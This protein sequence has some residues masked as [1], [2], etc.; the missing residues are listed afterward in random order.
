MSK[1]FYRAKTQRKPLSQD[2]IGILFFIAA[3]IF[4]SWFRL[5][6]VYEAQFP[7]N[8]GG[9]FYRMTEAII[10]NGFRLPEYVQY[11]GLSIPFAYP[12]LS[13]YIAGIT[14]AVFGTKLIQF[15]LYLPAIV[16]II[17]LFAF[18]ALANSLFESKLKAG[19][20]TLIF[21]L[22]PRSITWLIMGGGVTRSFGQLFLI[23]AVQNIYLLFKNRTKKY[24]WLSILFSS[25][26]CLSHPEAVV[27]TIGVALLLWVLLGRDRKGIILALEVAGG[28]IL[29]TSVWWLPTIN[30]FGIAPFVSAAQTGLHSA[31]AL[32]YFL[33]SFSEEPFLTII[34]VLAIIGLAVNVV[35]REF[36]LPL[37][38]VLP[39]LI[40][41][42]NAPNVSA[43][44]MA[45]LASTALQDLIFPALAQFESQIRKIEFQQSLQSRIEKGLFVYLG[46]CML[47][48]MY[49][50]DLTI[51]DRKVSPENQ[52]AFQWVAEN[53]PIDSRFLV[54]TGNTD[55]FADWTLEW[56][57][58]LTNRVSLTTIQ[59]HEWL[60]GKNFSEHVNEIQL[61]QHCLANSTPLAC[62]KTQAEKLGSDYDYIY[63]AKK[64]DPENYATIIRGDGLIFDILQDVRN[65]TEV[66][67][68]DDVAIFKASSD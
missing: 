68:T 14:S 45:L 13:F 52:K 32:V 54:L 40:E 48:G 55:L 57:P 25:L 8:D 64:T 35:R 67:Q 12:P 62:V 9:L 21:A 28:T 47:T 10:K 6:P 23:L 51:T 41:P 33:I 27:H 60:D 63:I 34:A 36:L 3:L 49:Y 59:G 65:F 66:Y 24:L 5:F 58:V 4:G 39:F 20:A 7:I 11:N 26:V 61:L 30:R 53:T 46:L 15:F 18:F 16:L 56:F 37:W 43:I 2:E 50:Y 17:T 1:M 31:N 42:R 38:Y 29:L 19:L 22:L 44:P